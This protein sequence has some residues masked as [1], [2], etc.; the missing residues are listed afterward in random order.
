MGTNSKPKRTPSY[1]L[2]RS[3]TVCSV[4]LPLIAAATW[5]TLSRFLLSKVSPRPLWVRVI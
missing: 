1:C 3:P 5:R 4:L 2:L